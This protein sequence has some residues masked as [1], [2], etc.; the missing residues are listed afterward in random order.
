MVVAN[1]RMKEENKGM[2][3]VEK[4]NAITEFEALL[5]RKYNNMSTINYLKENASKVVSLK[6]ANCI[7]SSLGRLG[8]VAGSLVGIITNVFAVASVLMNKKYNK[9]FCY[10]G[11]SIVDL[12]LLRKVFVKVGTTPSVEGYEPC[13]IEGDNIILVENKQGR[14]CRLARA[15]K[16]DIDTFATKISNAKKL[17]QDDLVL[18]GKDL[19]K[20]GRVM[21]ELEIDSAKKPTIK[22]GIL[23]LDEFMNVYGC[24][25]ASTKMGGDGEKAINIIN[26]FK[27]ITDAKKN[28]KK[29]P[30][31][32]EYELEGYDLIE[33]AKDKAKALIND[34]LAANPKANKA[35]KEAAIKKIT[36]KCINNCYIEDDA[37]TLK[38]EIVAQQ[39][40][41]LN[42]LVT[43]YKNSNMSLFEQFKSV[44]SRRIA[45]INAV[46]SE[47]NKITA[48]DVATMKE[49]CI[50]AIEMV[51][52]YFGYKA[53]KSA[54][55][56]PIE[57]LVANLRSALFIK[58]DELF[59]FDGDV[60]DEPLELT[61]LIAAACGWYRRSNYRGRNTIV[62]KKNYSYRALALLF[63]ME[64]KYFFNADALNVRTNVNLPVGALIDLDSV[65]EFKNGEAEIELEDGTMGT[66]YVGGKTDSY[67]GDVLVTLEEGE[68]V[69]YKLPN[70][71]DY[72]EQLDFMLLSNTVH[73][74]NKRNVLQIDTEG[75]SKEK[76]EAASIPLT[77]GVDDASIIS[78]SFKAFDDFVKIALQDGDVVFKYINNHLYIVNRQAN[79]AAILG[80]YNPALSSMGDIEEYGDAITF[81]SAR[82]ALIVLK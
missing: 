47:E 33:N 27:E 15:L 76:F 63:N 51:N 61:F 44:Y 60:S 24:K 53:E 34:Y 77:E 70:V 45:E 56:L 20:I 35:E 12:E 48:E 66:A 13:F 55:T 18:I 40:A 65:I 82:G 58:G 49:M 14:L 62:E 57:D 59:G 78:D 26:N 79:I 17:T 19:E 30:A 23:A 74:E 64:F 81:P 37:A 2:N 31:E 29:L 4:Q 7:P 69:F 43:S 71:Y 80:K 73:M 22:D 28:K 9:Q 10:A 21:Q 50:I 52:D 6:E 38:K 1:R 46:R 5:A 11:T 75:A 39:K 67:T 25:L 16:S 54:Q 41:K 32:F 8:Y 36:N 3:C 42:Q 68:V 72:N